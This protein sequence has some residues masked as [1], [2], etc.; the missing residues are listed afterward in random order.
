MTKITCT[1]LSLAIALCPS[2]FAQTQPG[3]L[4][5]SNTSV[6]TLQ[7]ASLV[8]APIRA[9]VTVAHPQDRHDRTVNRIWLSSMFAIVASSGFDAATSWGKR[10]GNGLLASSDGTFGGR[11]LSIKA[12]MAAAV[13]VPE[14]I[15]GHRHRDLRTKFAVGNFAEA[16]I[17]TAVSIHNLGVTAA[18]R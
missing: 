1:A 16:G 4:A 12:G 5:A 8:S 11:G 2:I 9:G 13:L 6:S 18:S 17:F 14:L 10:E 3:E 7:A 15:L